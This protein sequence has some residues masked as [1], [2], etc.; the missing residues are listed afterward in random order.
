MHGFF[1]CGRPITHQR[2]AKC[3]GN[4]DAFRQGA[5]ALR[6]ARELAKEER[7]KLVAAANGKALSAEQGSSTQSF[8]TWSS[9]DPAHLESETSAD[10]LALDNG[11]YTCPT[12]RM[13]VGARTNPSPK[14]SSNRRLKKKPI[15]VDR[16]S[17]TGYG[18][19]QKI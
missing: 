12:H 16:R 9:N 2:F 11:T 4:P 6:N 15:R 10:E 13:P 17:G 19:L 1:Y 18:G 5:S 8:V 7:E 3:R 14:T